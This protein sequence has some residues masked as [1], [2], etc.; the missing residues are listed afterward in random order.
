MA[1]FISVAN[2]AGVEPIPDAALINDTQN[3][4][5]LVEPEKTYMF[6]I[7]NIGAFAGQYL[8]F[9]NHTMQIVE[10]D[11]VYTETAETDMIYLTAAQ[12]YS[13]LVQT[14]NSTSS[15]FAYVASMDEVGET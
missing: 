4:S 15:N 14:K 3:L 11:G 1:G 12:R 7:I 10:I 6:R 8:W 2:P 9:E 13:V 5:T